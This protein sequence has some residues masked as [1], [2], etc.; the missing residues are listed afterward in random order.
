MMKSAIDIEELKSILHLLSIEHLDFFLKC[1]SDKEAEL[2]IKSLIRD[3]KIEKI[4]ES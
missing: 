3:K 4:L 1:A 2:L